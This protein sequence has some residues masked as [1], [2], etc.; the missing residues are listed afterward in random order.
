MIHIIIPTFRRLEQVQRLWAN[1]QDSNI[2]KENKQIVFIVNGSDEET[3][4]HLQSLPHPP[5]ILQCEQT[6][7]GEARNLGIQWVLS[8][9]VI[10]WILFLDDD[11]QLPPN[12]HQQALAIIHREKPHILGG[13]EIPIPHSTALQLA[14]GFCQAHP[15]VTGHT[16]LRHRLGKGSPRE[17]HESTLILCHLWVQTQIFREGFCFP[18]GYERNEENIFLHQVKQS[19]KKISYAPTLFTYH[20]KKKTTKAIILATFKSGQ[21]RMKSIIDEPSSFHLFFF[22]PPALTLYL[23]AILAGTAPLGWFPLLTYALLC[24]ALILQSWIQNK[25]IKIAFYN[26][27]LIPCIHLSYG[28]GTLWGGLSRKSSR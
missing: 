24:T 25:N 22:A 20:D 12:Y 11:V 8:Q 18:N 28:L 17:G 13:P 1:L 23:I 26:L 6:T 7:P 27:L 5:T 10:D 4:S 16:Y 14:Y 19:G 21:Y 3:K 15:L 2:V 9:K